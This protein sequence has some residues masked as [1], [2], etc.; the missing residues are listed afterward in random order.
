MAKAKGEAKVSLEIREFL[1]LIGCAVYSTEQGYRHDRG[2]TRQTP[3]IPDLIVFGIGPEMPFFFIE[4][5]APGGKLRDSQVAF[6]AEA[7]RMSVPYLVAWDVRDVFDWLV[8]HGVIE[9]P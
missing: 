5:K 8:E 4:V 7:H 9:T 6:Q 3:G 2:G 1:R